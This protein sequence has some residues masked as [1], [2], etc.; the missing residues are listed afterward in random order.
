MRKVGATIPLSKVLAFA[1][2]YFTDFIGLL[3]FPNVAAHPR[4]YG[5]YVRRQVLSLVRFL[6][7]AAIQ[8]PL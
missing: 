2:R 3:M 7:L 5:P 8:E 6:H 1:T 4:R